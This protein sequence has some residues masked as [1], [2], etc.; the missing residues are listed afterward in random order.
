L[1]PQVASQSELPQT[2]VAEIKLPLPTRTWTFIDP[3][4]QPAALRDLAIIA[5]RAVPYSRLEKLARE[6]AG[7]LLESVEP[8]DVYEGKPIPEGSR[9]V[10][11][12]LSFRAPGRTLTDAEVDAAMNDVIAAVKHEGFEIRG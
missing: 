5:P 8:F 7:A 12:H 11:I 9:S 10:A 2:F 3:S 6:T 1:H 4:R